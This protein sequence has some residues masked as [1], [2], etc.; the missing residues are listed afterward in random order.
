LISLQAADA[1]WSATAPLGGCAIHD[2]AVRS[3][4][5]AFM[6][7]LLWK[8]S[9]SLTRLEERNPALISLAH[10]RDKMPLRFTRWI[11]SRLRQ[12]CDG[13]A[14]RWATR[15]FGRRQART[16]C[17][18]CRVCWSGK[19]W[20]EAES[21]DCQNALS[22]LRHTKVRRVNLAQ[23]DLVPSV[24]EW[25]QQIEDTGTTLSREEALDIL[26]HERGRPV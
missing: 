9:H 8:V 3:P 18:K 21:A 19:L 15:K 23:V 7:Q 16:R 12:S 6:L 14:E 17:A 5:I 1:G 26:K 24:N 11:V 22:V 2:A 4:G 10:W 25:V 13:I 20:H